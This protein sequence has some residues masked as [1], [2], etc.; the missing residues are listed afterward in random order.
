MSDVKYWLWLSTAPRIG[1]RAIDALLRHYGSPEEMFFAPRGEISRLLPRR[2]EGAEELERRDLDAANRIMEKCDNQGIRVLTLA[3]DDYPDRLKNIFSPPAVLYVKGKLPDIDNEAA[4]A[5]IG[6]RKASVYGIKMG[7]KIGYEIAKC[8]GLV[9]SGLTMGIDSAAAEG[10]LLADASC[11]GVLGLPHELDKSRFSRDILMRG[12]LVSEYAPGTKPH[13]SFF[14]ARN[15]I[16]SGLSLGVVAVEAPIRSGTRLFVDEAASQGK[17][18]FAVPGN[19]DSN[20]CAGTNA[21]L[22][23][24]AKPVTDGWEVISEFAQLYPDKIKKVPLEMPQVWPRSPENRASEEPDAEKRTKKVIDKPD[25]TAYIDLKKQLEGLSPSQLKIIGVMDRASMHVDDIIN[26]SGFKP[27]KVL[28]DLTLLQ[29]KGFVR[30]EGGKH[31]T[32]NIRK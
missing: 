18:I 5:V 26:L 29:I 25:N 31:F 32:L 27:S 14:R 19:A 9:V 3:D 22:K 1:P 12:A 20:N 23:E 24:G 2:I 11:V 13:S 4:I 7:R 21:M 6:T 8:G 15:R 16:S 17:E 28:A 10:A 30:Q